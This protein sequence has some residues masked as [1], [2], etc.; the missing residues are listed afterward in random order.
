MQA[1]E[2]FCKES[3]VNRHSSSIENWEAVDEASLAKT[4]KELFCSLCLTYD[5]GYHAIDESA[6]LVFVKL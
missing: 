6:C 4:M 3:R 2:Y 1:R 5:C